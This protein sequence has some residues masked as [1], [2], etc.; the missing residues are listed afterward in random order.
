MTATVTVK[1]IGCGK[2]KEVGP[3]EVPKGE[4]PMCECMNP[5]VAVSAESK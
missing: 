2:T 3:G 5:M 1:C 4:M